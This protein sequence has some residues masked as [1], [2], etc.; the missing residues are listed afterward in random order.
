MNR[1]VAFARASLGTPLNAAVTLALV[2]LLVWALPPLW[3]WA[4]ADATW[5]APNRR[6]CNPDSACWAFIRARFALFFYG[7]YPPDQR[8]RVDFSAVLLLA[9]LLGALLSRR[10]RSAWLFA[11]LVLVPVAEGREQDYVRIMPTSPP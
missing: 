1:L 6:A 10:H 2:V 5:T 11:L 9:A 7:P 4:F 3:H 8:W